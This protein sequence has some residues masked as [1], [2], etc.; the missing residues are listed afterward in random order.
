MME[1][2]FSIPWGY[3]ILTSKELKELIEKA[4][5]YERSKAAHRECKLA[6]IKCNNAWAKQYDKLEAV[7]KYLD[8]IVIP[9][10]SDI[11]NLREILEAE[12]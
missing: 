9:S 11:F 2:G 12:K 4:E 8:N 10:V 6:L 1:S 5:K 3:T 7:K